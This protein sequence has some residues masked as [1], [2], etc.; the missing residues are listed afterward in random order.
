MIVQ[1]VY[2]DESCPFPSRNRIAH[3]GGHRQLDTGITKNSVMSRQ[4]KSSKKTSNATQIISLII[5]VVELLKEIF[6][7][8]FHK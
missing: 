8:F 6:T 1:L 7:C 2:H 5:V 3:L 4:K